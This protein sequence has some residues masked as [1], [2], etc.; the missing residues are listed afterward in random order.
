MKR[1]PSEPSKALSLIVPAFNEAERISQSLLTISEYLVRFEPDSEIVI[2]DDGS[3]DDTFEVVRGAA[4]DLPIPVRLLRYEENRGKG[5][6]LKV[7]FAAARGCKLLFSDADLS[8]PIEE[9]AQL[10]PLL[11]NGCDLV[12]GSRKMQGADIQIHQPWLRENMG[13]VFTWLVRRWI[14]DVSDVTC[15]FKAFNR[16]AGKKLFERVRVYDWSFDAEILHMA[17][18]AAYCTKE[19]PVRWEDREGT[20]V[21]LVRDTFNS[22]LGLVRIGLYSSTGRYRNPVPL[23][24]AIKEWEAAPRLRR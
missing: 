4:I 6:A 12:I 8:T 15:G 23:D 10:L 11:D 18:R 21:R 9:A 22:L 20:K 17:Q 5:Y 13:K 19:V 16:D 14:A 2:V 7:G 3:A 1:N 24:P